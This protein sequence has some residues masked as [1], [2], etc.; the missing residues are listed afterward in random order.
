VIC[1]VDI[2]LI[3]KTM[4]LFMKI[5]ICMYKNVLFYSFVIKRYM[6]KYIQSHDPVNTWN[7]KYYVR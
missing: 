4:L 3:D 7:K 2:H 5:N 6:L 1:K